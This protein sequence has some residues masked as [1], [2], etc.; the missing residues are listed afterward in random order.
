[1]KA[2]NLGSVSLPRPSRPKKNALQQ[3]SSSLAQA[4]RKVNIQRAESNETLNLSQ[5]KAHRSASGASPKPVRALPAAAA[6][7][8][9]WERSTRIMVRN[10]AAQE[11]EA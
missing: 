9:L 6:P 2:S 3:A 7:A 4:T 11:Q 10:S 5:I 1:M 8:R